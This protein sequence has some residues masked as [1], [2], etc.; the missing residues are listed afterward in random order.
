MIRQTLFALVAIVLTTGA[1]TGTAT[2]LD[3][4]VHTARI[5]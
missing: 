4:Q 5:A 3:A 2:V 1:F